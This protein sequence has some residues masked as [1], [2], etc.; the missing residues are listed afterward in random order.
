MAF[1]PGRYLE[2]LAALPQMT[3][4]ARDFTGNVGLVTVS[5]IAA[6]LGIGVAWIAAALA[7]RRLDLR[8]GAA[9]AISAMVLAQPTIGFN[10]AGLLLPAMALLWGRDRIAGRGLRHRGAADAAGAVGSRDR[11]LGLAFIS[12]LRTPTEEPPA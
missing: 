9:I 6:Y 2:Y 3:T 12:W 4:V 8:R 1:G 7:G 10:Y 5:P 11:R